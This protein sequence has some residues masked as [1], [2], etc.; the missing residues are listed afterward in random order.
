MLTIF[1]A[2][3]S[4]EAA[5]FF[6]LFLTSEYLGTNKRL[7]SNSVVQAFLRF[8]VYLKPFRKED[9]RIARIKE[10]LKG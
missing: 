10:S 1:G 3:V 8:V 4:Y 2:K 6:A 7:R 5:I 9:D